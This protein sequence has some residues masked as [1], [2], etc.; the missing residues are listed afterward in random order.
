M[1]EH[2]LDRKN[3]FWNTLGTGINAFNSLFLMIIVTRINGVDAA[4]IFT[5]AFSIS[6]LFNIIGVY[7]GRVYQVTDQSKLSD[8]DYLICKILTCV[9]MFVISFLFVFVNH[10]DTYKLLI[11]IILCLLRTFEAFSEVLYAYYQKKN[12]LYKV[13]FSLFIKNIFIL[14]VFFIVNLLSKNLFLSVTCITIAY[15]IIMIFYDMKILKIN[16]ISIKKFKKEHILIFFKE[17]FPTFC[18]TFLT[19]LLINIPRYIIDLKLTN[20]LNTIWG[21]IIMPATIMILLGQFFLHPFL[22]NL[23]QLYHHKKYKEFK[24]KVYQICFVLFIIG[25]SLSIIGGVIGI[26]VLEFIYG[27][28]LKGY[29]TSLFIILIGAILYGIVSV[30]YNLLVAIRCVFSQIIVY[31]FLSVFSVALNFV[32]IDKMQIVGASFSYFFVMFVA[33]IVYLILF[34]SYIKRKEN[35]CVKS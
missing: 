3:I 19:L 29:Q 16:K 11:I 32:L 23:F 28:S 2:S 31:L 24:K 7:S 22:M 21:I 33:L 8:S 10:Y 27:I 18:L 4:G 14:L 6:T 35:E 26:P 1:N 5:F 34:H 30:L 12:Q 17:G 9:L 15:L 25:I 13:G 20:E